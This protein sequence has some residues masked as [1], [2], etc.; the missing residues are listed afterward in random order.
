LLPDGTE[1]EVA[2]YNATITG[3]PMHCYSIGVIK[4]GKWIAVNIWNIDKF[5][6]YNGVLFKEIA[7]TLTL[8]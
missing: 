7:N 3:W 1:A 2:E 8:K 5:A 4:D 6:R